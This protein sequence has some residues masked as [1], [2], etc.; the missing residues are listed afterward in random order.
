MQPEE[1]R[2]ILKKLYLKPYGANTKLAKSLNISKVTVARWLYKSKIGSV[3][4]LLI[5]LM[6]ILKREGKDHYLEEAKKPIDETSH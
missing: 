3:E 6:V 1:L 4:A 2:I 5:R